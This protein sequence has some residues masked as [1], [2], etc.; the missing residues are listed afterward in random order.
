MR[1]RE[2]GRA[3]D[4]RFEDRRPAVQGR[5]GPGGPGGGD[6]AAVAVEAGVPTEFGYLLAELARERHVGKSVPSGPEPLVGRS[7]SVGGTAVRG[8]VAQRPVDDGHAVVDVVTGR[9]FGLQREAV[10]KL[11]PEVALLGVHRPDEGEL[12]GVGDGD[13]VALDAVDAARRGVEQHVHEMVAEQVHLVDVQQPA[14][15]PSEQPRVERRFPGEGVLDGERPDHAVPGR[16]EWER[17]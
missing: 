5:E 15:G 13:A 11:W 10:P 1:K 3:L 6:V 9:H 2:A 4:V 7:G 16:P 8:V 17:H 12:G 14:V